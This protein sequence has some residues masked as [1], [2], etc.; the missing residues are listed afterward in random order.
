MGEF[1]HTK[2][3]DLDNLEKAVMDALTKAKWWEDDSQ[4]CV[5]ITKKRYM[6]KPGVEIYAAE[7]DPQEIGNG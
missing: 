2:R 7:L 4:V 6:G 5:K 1:Y 3:P